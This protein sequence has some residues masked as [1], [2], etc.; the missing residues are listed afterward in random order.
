MPVRTIKKMEIMFFS[1]MFLFLFVVLSVGCGNPSVKEESLN[2]LNNVQRVMSLE[3]ASFPRDKA[4]RAS[5][6][7]TENSIKALE[8]KLVSDNPSI[9]LENISVAH[10]VVEVFSDDN[11]LLFS[12]GLGN[13]FIAYFELEDSSKSGSWKHGEEVLKEVSLE[14]KFPIPEKSRFFKISK[15]NSQ[16][17]LESILILDLKQIK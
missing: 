15:R 9:F 3:N 10:L 12:G 11:T 4:L 2:A 7:M 17:Q 1:W 8:T 16:G 5:F 14:I 13:P 6:L